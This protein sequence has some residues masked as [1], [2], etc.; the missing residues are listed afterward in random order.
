M[1]IQSGTI[2]PVGE[3][4]KLIN[5][6]KNLDK[7]KYV[8]LLSISSNLPILLCFYNLIQV[9]FKHGGEYWDHWYH[10][11]GDEIACFDDQ[12]SK[13]KVR[14]SMRIRGDGL[15]QSMNVNHNGRKR[16]LDEN[17]DDDNVMVMDPPKK[18]RRMSMDNNNKINNNYKINNNNKTNND[19]YKLKLEQI[20]KMENETLKKENIELEKTIDALEK[21]KLNKLKEVD[22][23][24]NEIETEKKAI[25]DI[26]RQL[27]C[28]ICYVNRKNIVILGC[29]HLDIC[30]KCE[31]KWDKKKCLRC[32]KP[33]T[34][35]FKINFQ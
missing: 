4:G 16:R 7:F 26:K 10:L 6:I 35:V 14:K 5:W 25:Q 15:H 27:E 33:Y 21:V 13:S 32:Q 20:Y 30:D 2:Q 17:S 28:R 12:A 9:T 8:Y 19:K 11:D 29:N 18:R 3:K 31:V 23:L 34:N 22:K 1:L 24:K